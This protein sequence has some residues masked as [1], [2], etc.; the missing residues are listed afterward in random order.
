MYIRTPIVYHCI[1]GSS[2]HNS[3]IK[4]THCLSP[5]MHMSVL[6]CIHIRIFIYKSRGTL[7]SVEKYM[8]ISVESILPRFPY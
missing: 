8:Q 3:N 4:Y 6:M 5:F 2:K 1:C 7:E